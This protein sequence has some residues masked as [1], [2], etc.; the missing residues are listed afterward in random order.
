VSVNEAERARTSTVTIDELVLADDSARWAALGFELDSGADAIAVGSVRIRFVEDDGDAGAGA[1]AA[2]GRGLLGWS[3]RGLRTTELDG[4]ATTLSRVPSRAPRGAH[5]NGVVAIDHLVVF[6]PALERTVAALQAAGLDLRRIREEPT[7][8]GAPRQAF[9]R[10][11]EEILEVIQLP[12][13]RL[14]LAGGP[15][16]PARLWGLA[17]TVADVDAAAAALAPHAGEA[18]EAVQQGRRIVTVRRSAGLAVPVALMSA[19]RP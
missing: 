16:A 9:F 19:R 15:D 2:R 7:P 13:E 5:P 1:D 11:G 17:F 10:L 12:E 8:A 4:I 18:H 14:D 6:S 3:L